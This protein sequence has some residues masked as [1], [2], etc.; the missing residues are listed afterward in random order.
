MKDS[1]CISESKNGSKLIPGSVLI[2]LRGVEGPNQVAK[3]K[4]GRN[5]GEGGVRE[6]W[7]KRGVETAWQVSLPPT[8]AALCIGPPLLCSARAKTRR[9]VQRQRPQLTSRR[10]VH[11]DRGHV[12]GRLAPE[13]AAR[14]AR[15]A[16]V[17]ARSPDAADTQPRR[18]RRDRVHV[19][20]A[21]RGGADAVARGTGGGRQS[22]RALSRCPQPR[23]TKS[24]EKKRGI[25]KE[26]LSLTDSG[27]TRPSRACLSFASPHPARAIGTSRD[28]ARP[29]ADSSC[30]NRRESVVGSTA[31][32]H[33][34]CRL[35]AH[36]LPC[37]AAL[38]SAIKRDGFFEKSPSPLQS[39]WR[40]HFSGV[41]SPARV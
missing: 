32:P 9:L 4:K 19:A 14:A 18:C 25:G 20:G 2:N 36:L 7:K 37:S 27:T 3:K 39:T 17:W 38:Q 34:S 31:P 8:S 24:K 13:P 28:S 15:R 23:K 33:Y 40:R 16:S 12:T 11:I 41:P 10:E 26:D 6:L 29:G 35:G 21:R 5:G 22:P 30:P 1:N